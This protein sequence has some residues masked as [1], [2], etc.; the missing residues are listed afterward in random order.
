MYVCAQAYLFFNK[1]AKNNVIEFPEDK[2]LH[3]NGALQYIVQKEAQNLDY[4]I[5][6][7]MF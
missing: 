4:C 5:N 6:H 1:K 7:P 3:D 2:E